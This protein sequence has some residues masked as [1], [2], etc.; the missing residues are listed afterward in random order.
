VRDLT[1]LAYRRASQIIRFFRM[2]FD[3][4]AARGEG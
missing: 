2:L 1:D 3:C 4:S